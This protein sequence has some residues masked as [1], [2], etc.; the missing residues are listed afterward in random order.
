MMHSH[1][2]SLLRPCLD[3]NQI[4]YS[5]GLRFLEKIMKSLITTRNFDLSGGSLWKKNVIEYYFLLLGVEKIQWKE[6]GKDRV[7]LLH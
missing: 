2:T 5:G 1:W 4:I 7:P 3:N 6:N